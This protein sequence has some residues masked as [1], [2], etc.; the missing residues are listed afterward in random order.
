MKIKKII[1]TSLYAE[2]LLAAEHFY[3]EILNLRLV[4]KEAGRHLFYQCGDS[5]LLIFNPNHTADEQTFVNGNPIPLHGSKGAGHIAFSVEPDEFDK[6]EKRLQAFNIKIES[7]VTWPGDVKSLYFR[8][9]ANNSI[10]II[11]SDL[12]NLNN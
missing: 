2:N 7:E 8:D 10:E 11:Q 12:W 9:P 1:E 5:M 4:R 3:G 6:W